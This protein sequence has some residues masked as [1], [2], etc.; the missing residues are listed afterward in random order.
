MGCGMVGALVSAAARPRLC[1][2]AD[3]ARVQVALPHHGAAERDEGRCGE[4]ELVR[5]QQRAHHHVPAVP[6][7]PVHLQD[8]AP[9]QVVQYQRLVCLRQAQ[10]PWQ[11]GV[12]DARPRASASPSVVTRD[13]NVL[14]VALGR[15]RGIKLFAKAAVVTGK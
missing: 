5:A 11:P 10:F 8:H 3:R 2:D 4:A 9:A 15:D 6:Q 7:L 13:D 12:F 1:S 14:R